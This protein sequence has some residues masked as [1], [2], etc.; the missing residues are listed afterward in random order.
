MN[1]PTYTAE[2][3]PMAASVQINVFSPYQT[4]GS[5]EGKNY[6]PNCLQCSLVNEWSVDSTYDDIICNTSCAASFGS[7][8]PSCF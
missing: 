6:L 7:T 8:N 5:A 1:N 4:V 3:Y 2:R